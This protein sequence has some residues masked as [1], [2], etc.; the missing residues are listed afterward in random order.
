[1]DDCAKTMLVVRSWSCLTWVLH[2]IYLLFFSLD[3]K[4][5]KDQDRQQ[6]SAASVGPTPPYV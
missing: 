6:R 5:T 4:E 3:R 2:A 1:M